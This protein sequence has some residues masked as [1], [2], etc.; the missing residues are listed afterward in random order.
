MTV[1]EFAKSRGMSVEMVFK[2][3]HAMYGSI[4]GLGSPQNMYHLWST[5]WCTLPIFVH[6]YVRNELKR[7]QYTNEPLLPF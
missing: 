3:A 2:N 5:G 6:R 7:E 1:Q 4:Y